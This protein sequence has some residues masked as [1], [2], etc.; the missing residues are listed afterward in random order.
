MN[1]SRIYIYGSL[2]WAV[3]RL[4]YQ[5]LQS[6]FIVLGLGLGVAVLTTV[7]TQLVQGLREFN[8]IV[9]RE[10]FFKQVMVTPK[11][12][13]AEVMGPEAPVAWPVTDLDVAQRPEPLTL[14]DLLDVRKNVPGV[15]YAL[16]NEGPAA[17]PAVA[18]DDEA[19]PDTHVVLG[20]VT[21]DRFRAD[22]MRLLAG[23]FFT[24]DDLVA[25]RPLL[26]VDE[27]WVKGF[28]P[29]LSSPAQAI[30]HTIVTAPLGGPGAGGRT[31]TIVGVVADPEE[32]EL[33][34]AASPGVRR[35]GRGGRFR[36][37]PVNGN[38]YVPATAVS[39]ARLAVPLLGWGSSSSS[40]PTSGSSPASLSG[41][42][43]GSSS[44]SDSTAVA[45]GNRESSNPTQTSNPDEPAAIDPRQVTYYTLVFQPEPGIS[46]AALARRIQAYLDTRLGRDRV[47]AFAPVE[48]V[49]EARREQWRS[50]AALAGLASLALFIGAIN[51]LNLNLA[52]V[53]QRQRYIGL[54]A[55]LGASRRQLVGQSLVEALSLGLGGG[56]LGAILTYPGLRLLF[57]LQ[58]RNVPEASRAQLALSYQLD[59]WVLLA[60]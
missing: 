1:G 34:S 48:Q 10:P 33:A 2:W 53:L 24:W 39:T 27:S 17:I 3:R 5:W 26:V 30:G 8:R 29:E 22:E 16:L 20:Q 15:R 6:F 11:Q 23:A 28:F 13:A 49:A 56:L 18:R 43:P 7:A 31:W 46:P 55:A 45:P 35:W 57:L 42:P 52:H 50:Y 44:S 59:P 38:A 9:E 37:R 36:G 14:A 51:V 40:S 60:G 21:P 19:V 32:E 25:A 41:S 4:R 58:T 47:Q 54:A 12:R